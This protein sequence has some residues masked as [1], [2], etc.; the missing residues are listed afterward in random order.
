MNPAS[1]TYLNTRETSITDTVTCPL[2][3]RN[4]DW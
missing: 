1:P 3:N 2:P 4:P